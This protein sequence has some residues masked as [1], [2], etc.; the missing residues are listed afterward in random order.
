[1]TTRTLG[2]A[3]RRPLTQQQ[4]LSTRR[5]TGGTAS[6]ATVVQP[7]AVLHDQRS[8][9][10]CVGQAHG[11]G[12][13]GIVGRRVSCVDL[14]EGARIAQK[15]GRDGAA[16][17]R[18]EYAIQ[19]LERHGWGD[20][21]DGEDIRPRAE[22]QD[23]KVGSSLAGAMR[24]AQRSGRI[25][26]HQTIDMTLPAREI[27]NQVVAALS[28]PRTYV[29]LEGGTAPAYQR[30]PADEVLGTAYRAGDSRGHAERIVGWSASREAF[31]LQGS[32]GAWTWCHLPDGERAM[33]CCLV[34]PA[35]VAR[36][37]AIDVVRVA[38]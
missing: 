3:R 21:V 35:V 38:E 14:W 4:W 37:W 7:L 18:G 20:Y 26:R 17:T 9:P 23:V 33:G 8:K 22:D 11:Q 16:G 19:W 25:A 24:A 34:S 5:Y 10:S 31:I 13:E 12:I 32:W 30:P 36:A 2:L 6:L 29:V 1:M 28:A 27:T 15:A